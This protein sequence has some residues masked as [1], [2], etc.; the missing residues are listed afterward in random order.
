MMKAPIAMFDIADGGFTFYN[1]EQWAEALV[2]W[3]EAIESDCDTDT[4][5]FDEYNLVECFFGDEVF[6]EEIPENLF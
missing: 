5:Y 1:K 4:S 6:I 2:E 3:R